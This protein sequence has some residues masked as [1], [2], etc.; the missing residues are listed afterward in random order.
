[1]IAR[2]NVVCISVNGT[3]NK[4]I[5]CGIVLYNLNAARFFDKMRMAS[6]MVNNGKHFRRHQP[7]FRIGQNSDQFC[8]DG[9][10]PKQDCLSVFHQIIYYSRITFPK[11]RRNRHI[12]VEDDSFQRIPLDSWMIFSISASV[13]MEKPFSSARVSAYG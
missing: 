11:Q 5:V 10:A 6:Q 4:N 7:K 8:F 13:R 12:C 3:L 1:M 2:N 9:P